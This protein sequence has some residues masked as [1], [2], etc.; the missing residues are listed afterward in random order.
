LKKWDSKGEGKMKRTYI[1]F[2][3]TI[4]VFTGKNSFA[5]RLYD[6]EI[7]RFYQV[8]PMS[9]KF[10]FTSPYVY[11][12]NNPIKYFD[13]NG[14]EVKVYSEILLPNAVSRAGLY[15]KAAYGFTWLIG[16]PMR[17]SFMRVT[18]DKFDIRIE[19]GAPKD[20]K[21]IG[22]YQ[23]QLWTPQER[24]GQA[25]YEVE[26]PDGIVSNNY[27][28]EYEIIKIA[29]L[30]EEFLPDYAGEGPN[31]NGFIQFLIEQAG[32]KVK[33]PFNAYG[34]NVMEQYRKQY[35]QAKKEKEEEE[36]KKEKRVR[37]GYISPRDRP[38]GYDPYTGEEYYQTN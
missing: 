38:L 4:L 30:I 22:D 35:Q 20:G 33:L 16:E 8:D 37:K 1:I 7:A 15:G 6:A 28:F 13:P 17:H 19:L 10:P 26:R 23:M 24:F 2:L 32:G 3:L 11:T 34:K 14:E 36:E 25:E 27:S 29:D 9:D 18:T 31:S 21:K 5:H 12:L